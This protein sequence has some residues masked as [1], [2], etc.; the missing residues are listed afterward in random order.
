MPQF[1][2]FIMAMYLVTLLSNRRIDQEYHIIFILSILITA[3]LF[4]HSLLGLYMTLKHPSPNPLD[5]ES[6]ARPPAGG[7]SGYAEP[8]VPIPVALAR[9]EEAVGIE[10]DAT[11][12]PPPAYGLWRDSV[13]VDPNRIF[14]KRN[15]ARPSALSGAR[16]DGSAP[17]P[18]SYASEDG[19]GYALANGPRSAL[20]SPMPI[21][22]SELGRLEHLG[23]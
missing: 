18:P 11:K 6:H 15:S 14:W 12:V 13:R 1:V 10:S 3:F 16:T 23:P 5:V 8:V 4:L 22:P 17:R 21:H 20:P 7:P 2:V 9:D 19:V